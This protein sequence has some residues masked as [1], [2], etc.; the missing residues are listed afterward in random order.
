VHADHAL[1]VFGRDERLILACLAVVGN[2]EPGDLAAGDV[3]VAVVGGHRVA[4]AAVGSVAGANGAVVGHLARP[5]V[6]LVGAGLALLVVAAGAVDH[7]VGADAHGPGLAPQAGRD[8]ALAREL[9]R[10]GVVDVDFHPLLPVGRG[11]VEFAVWAEHTAAD[12]NLP[13]VGD[14]VLPHRAG[15]QVADEDGGRA[16]V[17]LEVP[18]EEV[19]GLP[20]GVRHEHQLAAAHRGHGHAEFLDGERLGLGDPLREVRLL[21]GGPLRPLGGECVRAQGHG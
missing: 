10:R 2:E 5:G 8:H 19:V 13:A 3:D 7:P 4:P 16:A 18:L 14:A 11:E 21:N 15:G 17:A 9:V 12:V 1:D 6:N 20:V